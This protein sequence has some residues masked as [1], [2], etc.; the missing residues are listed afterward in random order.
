MRV[1]RTALLAALLPIA[2]LAHGGGR[3]IKGTIVRFDAERVV[4]NR[5]D[6][7]VEA[8]PLTRSTTYRVGQKAGSWRDLRAGSRVVVH[9]GHDGTALEIHLPARQ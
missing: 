2:A 7:Q 5:V 8:V 6:R 4:V 1:I 3:D 9:I